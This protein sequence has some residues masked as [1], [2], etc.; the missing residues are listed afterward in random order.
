MFKTIQSF[1]GVKGIA[2]MAT[3]LVAGSLTFAPLTGAQESDADS[4]RAERAE[5]VKEIRRVEN[6]NKKYSQEIQSVK[7]AMN[8]Q[9]Q[10]FTLRVD[11]LEDK[12][13]RQQT[14]REERR[15]ED[16]PSQAI[17]PDME[18]AT[19]NILSHGSELNP[20]DEAFRDELAKAHYNMG[21]IFFQ[22]GEYQRAVVEY[23]QSVDLSPYDPDTHYNLAFVSSEYLKDPE[24]ALKHYQWY[25]YLKPEANDKD[26]VKEKMAT[27]KLQVRGQ[28]DSPLDKNRGFENVIR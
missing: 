9:Q 12:I 24:T 6:L 27:A 5:F 4:L 15:R 2:L 22:R 18:E 7:E 28:I 23:Y 16:A 3:A 8:K 14:V 19:Y 11:Q 17:S 13:S 1:R 10:D 26:L 25:L 20:N 21:N